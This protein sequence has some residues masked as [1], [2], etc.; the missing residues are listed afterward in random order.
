[1]SSLDDLLLFQ[2]DQTDSDLTREKKKKKTS[3][4]LSLVFDSGPISPILCYS[5]NIFILTE[6]NLNNLHRNGLVLN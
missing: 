3:Q 6:R 4:G 1:M 5:S 2:F